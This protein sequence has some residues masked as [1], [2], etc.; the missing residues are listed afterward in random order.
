MRRAKNLIL[1]L[2]CVG[3]LTGCAAKGVL[4]THLPGKQ[5]AEQLAEGD[6]AMVGANQPGDRIDLARYAVLGKYTVFEFS[7]ET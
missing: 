6:V 1:S 5:T 2:L 3:I 7:S 4:S